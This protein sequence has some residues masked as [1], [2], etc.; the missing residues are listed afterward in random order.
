MLEKNGQPEQG[1]GERSADADGGEHK[2]SP[3]VVLGAQ[4]VDA[5]AAF[6]AGI[7]RENCADHGIGDGD[8]KAGE[9]EWQG[10]WQADQAKDYAYSV[11][12]RVKKSQETA[13]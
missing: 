3:K 13:T 10:R 5:E 2:S 12:E 4:H 9:E 6:S 1:Q 7:F 8:A 11:A